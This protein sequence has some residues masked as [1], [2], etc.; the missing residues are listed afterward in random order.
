MSTVNYM[1]LPGG[2]VLPV[3]LVTEVWTGYQWE[4]GTVSDDRAETILGDFADNYLLQRMLAG[5]ILRQDIEFC[6][7]DGVY[8]LD[9]V[10]SCQEMIGREQSEETLGNYGKTD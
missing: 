8:S 9:G 3:A 6:G 1:T 10:Y 4:I 7:K 2:F 5:Q